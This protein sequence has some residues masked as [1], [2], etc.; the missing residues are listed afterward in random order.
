M[1]PT[2]DIHGTWYHGGTLS[3]VKA[4]NDNKIKT[5]VG[6]GELGVGF[7]IGNFGHVASAWA[8]HKNREDAAVAQIDLSGF[9]GTGLRKLELSWLSAKEHYIKIGL[10]GKQRIY[11]FGHDVVAAPIV[12]R[13]M[14]CCPVQLKWEGIRS[15]GY[16]NS[17]LVHKKI[18]KI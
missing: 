10:S 5:S 3:A 13:A 9:S 16:L 12:G 2:Y 11:N 1:K 15:E 6:G 8:R 4:I 17:S 18:A 14:A 7:Y